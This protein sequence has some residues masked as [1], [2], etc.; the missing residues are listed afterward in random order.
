MRK[1]IDWMEL[2]PYRETRDYVQRVL[3]NMQIYRIIL[4]KNSTF[5]FR[6]DLHACDISKS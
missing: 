5:K 2:I 1:V 3:E 6:Q 4:N